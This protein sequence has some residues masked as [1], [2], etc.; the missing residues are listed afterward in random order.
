MAFDPSRP[1]AKI[2]SANPSPESPVYEQDGVFYDANCKEVGKAD[3]YSRA[4]AAKKNRP[5]PAPEP[6][7]AEDRASLIIGAVASPHAEAAKEN[8]AAAAAEDLSDDAG[9]D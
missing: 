2:I 6:A 7:S 3:G 1:H 4:Q 8:A 5:E 9:E